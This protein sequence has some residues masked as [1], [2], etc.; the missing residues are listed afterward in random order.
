[1]VGEISA[2]GD[3]ASG[4]LLARAVE[5]HA[6]EE[7]GF[8]HGLCLNCGTA[9]AGP[10]CHAC[11]QGGHVHKTLASI[12]HDLLH[13]VFHF[14]GKIWRTLPMLAFDPGGL[15]RRYIAGERARFVSPLAA[16]LFSVFLM[17][18]V[19]GSLPGWH[20]DSGFLKPG[21][22][23]GMVKAR[24][25]L[26]EE[27]ARAVAEIEADTRKLARERAEAEPDAER[28]AKLER[29]IA[30][31]RKAID[32]ADQAIRLLPTKVDREETP[33]ADGSTN[34]NIVSAPGS[35]GGSW[36]EQKWQH[37][38][39]N[40]QLLLY[41]MKTSAYKYSWALIPISLPFIWLLFPFRRDVG[42]YDH[43]IFATY[44]LTFMSL[45]A[46]VLAVLAA[47]GVPAGLC[48]TAAAFVPPLH[49]YKQLK[50]AYGLS[51]W[52]GLWRLAWLLFFT[53][54]TIT[55]FALALLWF[56]LEG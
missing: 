5:P 40:P 46:I 4:A 35:P 48:W 34:F 21:A 36:I 47:V 42:M 10:Y 50:G 29:R 53:T 22:F 54:F 8:P 23:S 41:K 31:D 45:L 24:T 27:R 43:A 7:G 19:V 28:I 44:S 11:G 33:S 6:G 15:T 37:A 49:L 20:L 30:A 18:A 52:G 3:I 16:F 38:K 2:A 51:R 32:Q 56:G 17:F 9:R 1:M 12:G 39:E 25:A 13:G 55:F 14:E 26:A